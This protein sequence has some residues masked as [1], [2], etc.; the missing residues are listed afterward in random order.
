MLKNFLW[1]FFQQGAGQ[2]INL[3]ITI[4]LVRLVT[5][6]EFGLIALTYVFYTIAERLMESGIGESFIRTKDAKPID[7]NTIFFTTVSLSIVFYILIFLI[8]PFVADFYNNP[9]LSPLIRVNSIS[10]ILLALTITQ[11]NHLWKELKLKETTIVSIGSTIIGGAIGVTSAIYNYGVWSLVI[12]NLATGLLRLLFTLYFTIW[13]PRFMFSFK[14]LKMHFNFGIKLTIT[15][16]IDALYKNIYVLIIGKRFDTFSVGHYNRADS[17]KN[18]L[19]VLTY[20]SIYKVM[21]PHF[22]KINEDQSYESKVLELFNLIFYLVNYLIFFISTV[23][24]ISHSY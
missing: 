20:M 14:V 4:F 2:I 5:P 1:S 12:T 8:A 6:E 9:I 3:F 24:F 18:I 13:Q 17:T 7:F 22:S 10:I 19:S 16:L 11:T 21:F 15:N 23:A